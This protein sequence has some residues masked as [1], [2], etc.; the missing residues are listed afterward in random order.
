MS[1][2]SPKARDSWPTV[3]HMFETAKRETA[4]LSKHAYK[5]TALTVAVIK[6]S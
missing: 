1:R 5:T 6:N 3:S 2:Y 4:R